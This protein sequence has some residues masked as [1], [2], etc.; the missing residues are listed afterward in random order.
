M[1]LQTIERHDPETEGAPGLVDL[2]V[3]L[4]DEEAALLGGDEMAAGE[5]AHLAAWALILLRTLERDGTF[6]SRYR[7]KGDPD[8]DL[9]AL[10]GLIVALDK[11]V[12][13]RLNGIRDAAIRAHQDRGGSY[14]QL[15]AAM[16]VARSTA[17]TRA[18]A[19][20]AQEPSPYEL[21]AR[22]LG[23]RPS[24]PAPEVVPAAAEYR[25]IADRIHQALEADRARMDALLARHAELCDASI[26]AAKAYQAAAK[27]GD[28]DTIAA[29]K[30]ASD[31]ASQR[32]DTEGAA[33]LAEHAALGEEQSRRSKQ[34]AD[35]YRHHCRR[36]SGEA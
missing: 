17:Q 33:L 32:V 28:P 12:L 9:A 20:T 21:W 18:D 15:A 10:R 8:D 3:T 5:P 29:A 4:T 23:P 25:E 31:K 35:A 14:G 2:V 26:A 27:T 30:D 6:T 24:A 36:L 34:I 1:P 13:P 22:G 11:T 7:E 16:N 19:L